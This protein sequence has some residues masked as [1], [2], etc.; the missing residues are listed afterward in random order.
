MPGK[1]RNRRKFLADGSPNPNYHRPQGWGH[2]QRARQRA[3][4]ATSRPPRQPTPAPE[5]K[6]RRPSRPHLIAW[7]GDGRRLVSS[8]GDELAAPEGERLTTWQVLD[9]LLAHA[10]K[11]TKHVA[12]G[13][14]GLVALWLRD[15][16]MEQARELWRT[17]SLRLHPEGGMGAWYY[18]HYVPGKRFS[19]RRATWPHKKGQGAHTVIADAGVLLDWPAGR[20]PSELLG[21][22]ERVELALAEHDL[23]PHSWEGPGALASRFLERFGVRLEMEDEPPAM[24]EALLHGFA[25]GRAE[26]VQFGHHAGA[27]WDY[28][29]RAAY[30]WAMTQLPR[31]AGGHWRHL[32]RPGDCGAARGNEPTPLA[33]YRVRWSAPRPVRIGPFPWRDR[34]QWL[35]FPP[36]GENWIWLPELEAAEAAPPCDGFEVEL[37]EGWLFSPAR[38]AADA[39]PWAFMHELYELRRSLP[40]PESLAVK[41]GSN[42][43][44]GKLM[45]SRTLDPSGRAPW[46]QLS[47][48]GCLTSM[49]RA[50]LYLAAMRRPAAVVAFAVDGLLTT[51]DLGLELG[52]ELGAWSCDRFQRGLVVTS[53]HVHLWDAGGRDSRVAGFG[54]DAVDP[55][56]VLLGWRRG[57]KQL[58]AQ[59]PR[60]VLLGEA[61]ASRRAW[62]QLGQEVTQKGTCRLWEAYDG[63][64]PL[65]AGEVEPWNRLVPLRSVAPLVSESTAYTSPFAAPDESLQHAPAAGV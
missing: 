43:C 57:W 3:E 42:A 58:T 23:V 19:V 14:D 4:A 10:N 25:A 59:M 13:V 6:Q 27:L 20:P 53:Q 38:D 34:A 49:V 33:L 46:Q 1:H 51:A 11:R 15:L 17:M 63:H 2:G 52:E 35:Y 47:W 44:A 22:V 48:A 60:Q 61:Q 41:Y 30:P 37:L 32:R 29:V 7:E 54:P 65:R 45:Q 12:A 24:R 62:A 18:L 16:T 39:R 56:R 36:E 5:P 55:E 31:L 9:F 28:D 26:A 21:S 50:R 64:L 8:A 40:K